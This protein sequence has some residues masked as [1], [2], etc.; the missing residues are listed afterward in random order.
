MVVLRRDVAAASSV[1]L[2]VGAA[3]AEAAEPA[4][5]VSVVL[6]ANAEGGTISIVDA[7]RLTVVKELDIV[8]DGE[9][10]AVGEDDPV[11]PLVGQRLVEAAGG[12]NL[13]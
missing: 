8:P 10:A 7:S 9:Q 5:K 1:V 4:P 12:T 6:V 13:A 11:Q 3:P 2:L